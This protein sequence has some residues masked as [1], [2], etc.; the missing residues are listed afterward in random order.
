MINKEIRNQKT[1]LQYYKVQGVR[2]NLL[3]RAFNIVCFQ[4]MIVFFFAKISRK[5]SF[6]ATALSNF[7]SFPQQSIF[8]RILFS[9]KQEV[10][11]FVQLFKV[12]EL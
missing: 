11:Y 8:P 6:P 7:G 2:K 10:Q 5:S 12:N 4:P 3:F 9:Y 1:C